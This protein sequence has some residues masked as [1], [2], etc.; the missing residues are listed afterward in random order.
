MTTA[1][2]EKQLVH[3][4][5]TIEGKKWVTRNTRN[6]GGIHRQEE[7]KKGIEMLEYCAHH[8]RNPRLFHL[9][10]TGA[11]L[12]IYQLAMTRFCRVLTAEGIDY[13]YKAAVEKDSQKGEHFHVMIVLGAGDRQTH[14]FITSVNEEGRHEN[15]SALRKAIMHTWNECQTLKCRVNPPRSSSGRT[16]FLQFNQSNMD[17]FHEAAEWMSYIYKSRSK[18][19]SGTVYFSGRPARSVSQA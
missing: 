2:T 3:Y 10:F 13:R 15:V 9:C 16:A 11:D 12:A 1:V 19:A 5:P 4:I 8:W 17:K 14:R 6:H 7:F 18:P